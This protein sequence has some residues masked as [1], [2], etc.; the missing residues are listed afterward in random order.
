MNIKELRVH[1]AGSA[2][3]DTDHD[4]LRY[5]HDLVAE[6][7][8]TLIVEGAMFVT[9]IGKEPLS[10][11]NDYNSPSIIFDW[12]ILSTIQ[13]CLQQGL[14]STSD[15]PERLVY[16]VGKSKT[17]QQI[18]EHRRDL[19]ESFLDDNVIEIDYLKPGRAS[20]RACRELQASRGDILIVI[21]GGEGAEEL[22]EDLYIENDKPVIPLDLEIGSSCNDGNDGASRLAKEMLAEPHR[23][24]RISDGSSSGSLVNRLTTLQGKRPVKEV[25]KSILKLIKA[26]EPNPVSKQPKPSIDNNRK[27][28][29]RPQGQNVLCA[30]ILT[31]IPVEYMAVRA[32]LADLQKETHHKGTT[33]YERGKFAAN[34]KV[35][36][37]GIVEMG[38][39]NSNAALE[40][41]RA[42]NYFN[43]HVILLVGVA[44]G[45]KDKDVVLGD[46]VAAT[47]VYGYESGKAEIEFKPRPNVGE[48]AYKLIKLARL[49]S[50]EEDWMQRLPSP[51]PNPKP[52]V[53]VAPIA[54]GEQ[55]VADTK[56]S[57]YKL[58]KSNYGDAIAVEM[59]GRG[60]LQAA[61]ANHE[62][63]PLIVR[64]ISDLI[65]GKSEAD[66]AGS[67]EI[68]ARHASAFAF[69]VLAEFNVENIN[70]ITTTKKDS[71]H[72]WNRE[73]IDEVN[74]HFKQ[75]ES[76]NSSSPEENT[77]DII[78]K[79]KKFTPEKVVSLLTTYQEVTNFINDI[80]N[81]AERRA[82]KSQ[83][84]EAVFLFEFA[85]ATCNIIDNPVLE[86][87]IT[88]NLEFIKAKLQP[89]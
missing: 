8:R 10:I 51:V 45:M 32:H 41:E 40:A 17:E 57:T 18:P 88:K 86:L 35:W 67:Q 76:Y 64:G 22:A 54:A 5:A 71:E 4:L 50:V 79:L 26:L 74:S 11:E 33:T 38:A 83:F 30:V 6:L 58:L 75:P 61:H 29:I 53:F 19:W 78:E 73:A 2:K 1:I 3:P 81:E 68:A 31:A 62:V 12:T 14:V 36:E 59:E 89:S 46:V 39:G 25:V 24:V 27:M 49:E 28:T 66:A 44:G 16:M 34:G 65:D 82:K 52:R 13:D 72:T 55:V 48:C 69:Q 84:V 80:W 77:P 43:P 15:F 23:F 60:F 87:A 56:S 85:I 63:L 21:S 47:K 20:G 7:V 70:N 37:V 9:S 42:I